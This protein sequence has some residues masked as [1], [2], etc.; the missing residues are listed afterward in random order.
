MVAYVILLS[1]FIT[2]PKIGKFLSLEK[3]GKTHFKSTFCELK[4][5]LFSEAT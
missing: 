4:V 5:T 1:S 3:S 2:Q